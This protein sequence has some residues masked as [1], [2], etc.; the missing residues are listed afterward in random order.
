M[1][2]SDKIKLSAQKRAYRL[3]FEYLRVARQSTK[4]EVK[5]A[6]TAFSGAY[7]DWNMD[8]AKDFNSWWKEH[9]HLFEEKYF[10]RPLQP[11]EIPSDPEALILEIPL[12]QSPTILTKTVKAIIKEAFSAKGKQERK[13]K[14]KATARYR[15]TE[16]SEPKFDAIR[17]MLSIYRDVY[18]KNPSSK[19]RQLLQKVHQY[20]T[21][22]KNQYKKIPMP[23][24][25]QGGDDEQ[26]ALRNLN[27]YIH[28][29]ERI[30]LN[31]ARGEFPGKY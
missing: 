17:E 10:V 23:F 4:K 28:K 21:A 14:R 29:A 2:P 27:R 22:R 7:R 18:L 5:S 15:L 24:Q 31:V 1:N 30:V 26:R 12:T 9:S 6:L 20:Y 3:W 19:G 16:D 11:G 25:H 13:N 8:E